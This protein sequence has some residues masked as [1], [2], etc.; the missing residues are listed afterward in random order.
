M[1]KAR[2]IAFYLP[3]FHP[4]PENDKYW[5]KGFTEWTNVGKAKPLFR[6]HYQ[7]RIP[8][9]L[10]YYDLRIPEIRE[11]Q[12]QMAQENG[13]EGFMYWHY[14][15][16]N[17]RRVLERPF[18]EVLISGKPNFPF[19][20]GWANHSWT[21]RTW[22]NQ[23]Q[24]KHDCSIIK[25]LYPGKQDYLNHF[26]TVL[27]AFQDKRYIQVDGKPVFLFYAPL[28]FPDIKLFMELWQD[29]A[30]KNGLNGVHFVGLSGG[31]IEN[32][33]KIL[34]L[35]VDAIAPGNL[36]HAEYKSKGYIRKMLEH[37]IRDFFPNIQLDRYKYKTIIKNYFTEF[38]YHDN[39]YPTIIPQ[40]DRSPRSGRKAIIYTDS[41]PELFK[42]HIQDALSIISNKPEEKKII[43][44][45]SWNEWG[46]GNYV[47]PDLKFGHGYLNVL[48][49]C[50]LNN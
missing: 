28:D 37:K 3:Q 36:W 12:A 14:W 23:N 41:T 38:D 13:I 48:K 44:L 17:G 19:C 31:W 50:I 4:I 7:P 21:T 9:D 39:V 16:G 29:N 20:L 5:G 6:G 42:K 8:A 34:D 15:F 46:E 40:W 11:L 43:F 18:N 35:G 1:K 33:Q 32:N 24:W 22:V 26:Y 25:Q 30:I 27:P 49:E 10:G 2:V 45:R 47:E